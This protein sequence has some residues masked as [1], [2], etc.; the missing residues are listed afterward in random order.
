MIWLFFHWK[1]TKFR[2]RL[3]YETYFFIYIS[4]QPFRCVFCSNPPFLLVLAAN[5]R[6]YVVFVRVSYREHDTQL[7]FPLR[8]WRH[9]ASLLEVERGGCCDCLSSHSVPLACRPSWVCFTFSCLFSLLPPGSLCFSSSSHEV[10]RA[11][12]GG[13]RFHV[14]IRC[15]FTSGHTCTEL[16]Y[17][18]W[19][20]SLWFTLC[21]PLFFVSLSLFVVPWFREVARNSLRSWEAWSRPK[22]GPEVVRHGDTEDRTALLYAIVVLDCAKWKSYCLGTVLSVCIGVALAPRFFQWGVFLNL[23][24]EEDLGCSS[25]YCCGACITLDVHPTFIWQ[26]FDGVHWQQKGPCNLMQDMSRRK[27]RLALTLSW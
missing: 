2:V 16:P 5:F 9:S 12:N 6:R 24:Y 21:A 18:V 15:V 4:P 17:F 13:S 25:W 26:E 7:V 23:T 22:G 14:F 11:D 27:F 20:D 10:Q 3:I 8:N 1:V 19:C